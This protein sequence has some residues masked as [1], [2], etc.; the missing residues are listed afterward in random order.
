MAQTKS[1]SALIDRPEADSSDR[2]Q[3][4]LLSLPPEL[5]LLISSYLPYP[6]ALSLKHSHPK[7]YYLVYTGVKLKVDWLISRRQL[8]LECPNDG[9]CLLKTDREFC[10]GSVQL[11]MRRRRR[12]E[13]C[14][15]RE[16]G[17]GCL[18]R[19]TKSCDVKERMDKRSWVEKFL[20]AALEW[21][22][23]RWKGD[24]AKIALAWILGVVVMAAVAG[25]VAPVAVH[26]GWLV[27]LLSTA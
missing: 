13:E 7:F 10:R 4:N 20:R 25:L 21:V 6:D 2:E 11:L 23:K 24:G 14:E 1:S 16:G 15:W 22:E 18:V 26:G 12:H 8:H 9:Q 27:G 17:R 19:G 3:I 5:H